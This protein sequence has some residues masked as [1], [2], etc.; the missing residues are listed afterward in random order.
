MIIALNLQ[1]LEEQL[2]VNLITQTK[3][4][5]QNTKAMMDPHKDKWIEPVNNEHKQMVQDGVIKIVD[6]EEAIA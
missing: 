4:S 1:Q 6:S 3:S 5:L 2:E